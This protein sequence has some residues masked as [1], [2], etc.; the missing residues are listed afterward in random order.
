MIDD[1]QLHIP[2]LVAAVL[3]AA[4]TLVRNSAYLVRMWRLPHLFTSERAAVAARAKES[5][6]AVDL[7]FVIPA[8]QEVD[9]LPATFAALQRSIERS[10]YRAQITVVTSITDELKASDQDCTRTIAER[11][12]ADVAGSRVLV[13]PSPVP[14]MASAFNYGMRRIAAEVVGSEAQAYVVAYN[15]DSTASPD[16]V[17]AL[18]DTIVAR[19]LPEV[20]QLNYTSLRNADLM[21]GASG[22]Y[23]LGAA[24]YQTRW[25]LGFEFDLHRRNSARSRPQPLGHSYHLKGHGLVLRLDRALTLEGLSTRTP[26]ED[27]ELGFRLSLLR[28]PVVPVTIMEDTESPSTAVAVTAQ[29]RYWFSGMADVVNFHRLHPRFRARGVFRYE[30]QRAASLYRSA[31]CFLLAPAPY[32]FL[33]LC[34]ILLG[35]LWLAAI[36]I[37]SAGLSVLFIRRA[38]RLLGTGHSRLRFGEIFSLPCAVPVWSMTRNIGP[39]LYLFSVVRSPDRSQR[40]RAVHRRHIEESAHTQQHR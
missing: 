5:D 18:G 35:Q 16:T 7:H 15:A 32:W 12:C 31:G 22:W 36:P 10:P 17:C 34:G 37:V 9:A 21:R 19:D 40:L 29:K 38:L 1:P 25:A 23:A 14:S 6:R 20:L 13:D 33:A 3:V 39:I 11:L 4:L 28:V 2:L 27:L 8:Y 30:L 26:C 24:Y